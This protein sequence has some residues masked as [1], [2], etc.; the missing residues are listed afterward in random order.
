MITLLI[1]GVAFGVVYNVFLRSQDAFF[2]QKAMV[3]A[4]QNARIALESVAADIRQA[5]Y[6]KDVTQA[7]VTYA[8]ADSVA[9]IADVY[10]TIPGAETIVLFLS[11]ELDSGTVNP[12]DRVIH[13]AV[14]DTS[15][16]V[17]LESP[18][19]YG[20]AAGGLTFRF[21]DDD[22]V[23][24]ALPV[25]N[26]DK[27]AEVEVA[28]TAETPREVDDG[29][30]RA[31]SVSTT[32]F[33]RNLPFS[34]SKAKPSPP[35]ISGLSSPN[36][37]S[38]TVDW[39]VPSTYTDGAALAF[40]DISHFNIYYGTGLSSMNLD[41]RVARNIESWTVRNLDSQSSYII[42]VTCVTK[43]GVESSGATMSGTP[44][45]GMAPQ[46]PAS[47]TASTVGSAV[48]LRWKP[49][50]LDV[51]GAQITAEVTYDVHRSL[52]PSTPPTSANRIAADLTD[53]T[54]VDVLSGSCGT[55]YYRM[56]A[57]ACGVSSAGTSDVQSSSVA[58]PSCV[59]SVS[60]IDGPGFGEITVFWT[61]P[62][63]RSDGSPLTAADLS[64]YKIVYGTTS[65]VYTDTLFVSGGSSVTGLLSGLATCTTYFVNVLAVDV[66]DINGAIC[67]L[68]QQIAWTT[69][70]CDM[71]VPQMPTGLVVTPADGRL[72]LVWATNQ[73]CDIAGYRI[74]YDHTPGP[75][76]YGADAA[77]GPSPIT[78]DFSAAT[79]DSTTSMASLTGLIPC[80]TYYVAISAIDQ[81]PVP[82]ESPL[83]LLASGDPTCLACLVQNACIAEYTTGSGSTSAHGDIASNESSA[84]TVER[85]ELSWKSG[86]GLVA[87]WAAGTKVWAAD[88]SAGSDGAMSPPTSPASLDVD[89]WTL[90]A[91]AS[92]VAPVHLQ[93]DFNGSALGD[94]IVLGLEAGSARCNTVIQPCNLYFADDFQDDPNGVM[95]N[96]W[97]SNSGTWSAS[98]NQLKSTGT[99]A[100][101]ATPTSLG[102]LYDFT[103]ETNVKLSGTNT[104]RRAGV[105]LRYVDSGNYYLFR[106]WPYYQRAELAR[107]VAS[108]ALTT[109]AYLDGLPIYDN[110]NHLIRVTAEG[111]TF[112]FWL[113]GNPI[114]WSGG[115]SGAVLTDGSF[116][117]GQFSIHSTSSS[118]A[119][120]DNIKLYRT[121]GGCTP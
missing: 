87:V 20:I 70:P 42:M 109:I 72:D 5:S 59:A 64:G 66:C 117:S 102:T 45:T 101:R 48:T 112:R 107:K 24:F 57:V 46:S 54:Y 82:N 56:T 13:K 1:L 33:P 96:G 52:S 7:S 80:Q 98:A 30:Y 103:V 95:P 44:T 31:V 32:I 40:N 120:F 22:G 12:T 121:C 17:I 88:G 79:V 39:D 34:T 3:E 61:S 111:S 26:P 60:A 62:T 69:T 78:I 81:C 11:A 92:T 113:D 85:M 2:S 23:E 91:T 55:Y 49:V 119:F 36:C 58:D 25:S 118:S 67:A 15:G 37:E 110:Y 18:I 50:A 9:F 73:D 38:I 116:S 74:Y 100:A 108:G 97:T 68:N 65:G 10:D 6:G 115:T 106:I 16:A 105:Y 89:D 8:A 19:A 29:Q 90:P 21:F 41:T 93:V 84:L 71:A 51:A 43:S 4:Q 53:T 35:T 114:Y 28:V 86:Q 94:S 99:T 104:N 77:E 47:P 83:S 75:P 63:T 27:I 14:Y 76:F